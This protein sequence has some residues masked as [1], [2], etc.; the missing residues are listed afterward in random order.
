VAWSL[1]S[2][3]GLLNRADIL[4]T[5]VEPV[6]MLNPD[7][8]MVEVSIW[9]TGDTFYINDS[10]LW[11]WIKSYLDWDGTFTI[12]DYVDCEH[13]NNEWYADDDELA[14]FEADSAGY[15]SAAGSV[16]NFVCV[17]QANT[18]KICMDLFIM[19]KTAGPLNGDN[20]QSDLDF[21]RFGGRVSDRNYAASSNCSSYAAGLM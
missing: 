14:N 2:V 21:T 5:E 19:A 11:D 1:W 9:N 8:D 3:V 6:A 18:Q 17:P 10:D 12:D 4:A 20:R 16:D 7:D 15:E 13:A